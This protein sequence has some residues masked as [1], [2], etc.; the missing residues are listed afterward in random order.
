M[1]FLGS[2]VVVSLLISHVHADSRRGRDG[3]LTYVEDEPMSHA[4]VARAPTGDG[5]RSADGVGQRREIVINAPSAVPVETG[6]AASREHD[7]TPPATPA[8][9]AATSSELVAELAARQL[10]REA[11]RHQ[12]A[13]DG[14]LTAAARRHPAAVGTVTLALEIAGHKLVAVRVSDDAVH[15]A[16]LATCLTTTARAFRFSLAAARVS[17]PVTLTPSASR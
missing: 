17:W 11:R 5:T 10:S 8:D 4:A 1:R 7:V 16:E 3:R 9:S 15:D 13:I 2:V 14:C 6:A 12:A